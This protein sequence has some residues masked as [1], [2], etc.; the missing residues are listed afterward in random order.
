RPPTTRTAT[1]SAST[2]GWSTRPESGGSRSGPCGSRTQCRSPSGGDRPHAPPPSAP[3]R[4]RPSR[5]SPSRCSFACR[6]SGRRRRPP[7]HPEARPKDAVPGSLVGGEPLLRP[8][9]S[10]ITSAGLAKPAPAEKKRHLLTGCLGRKGGPPAT[11]PPRPSV[12]SKLLPIRYTMN[13]RAPRPSVMMTRARRS[14]ARGSMSST[15]RATEGLA[16]EYRMRVA[17][18][19]L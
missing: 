11:Q 8:W 13:P 5:E 1:P 3:S 12:R 16:T 6:E 15:S 17:P 2:S 10:P 18:G 4:L 7:W 19:P 9:T 14:P